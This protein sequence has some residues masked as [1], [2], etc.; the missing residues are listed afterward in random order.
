M[1]KNV[2]DVF[3]KV[4]GTDKINDV[5]TGKGA[6]SKVGFAD[7]VSA[8]AN[9]TSFSIKQYDKDGKEVGTTNLSEG[10][11]RSDSLYCNGTAQ[12]G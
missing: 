2:T 5:L 12:A 6:F 8:L 10:Y 1:A 4:K 11:C 9:D 3:G 7:N